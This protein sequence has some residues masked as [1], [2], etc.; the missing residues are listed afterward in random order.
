MARSGR[1][2]ST[3]TREA[4][5]MRA[6]HDVHARAVWGYA[7][8]LTRGD[9]ARAEDIVQETL[10]RAWRHPEVLDRSREAVRAWLLTTARRIAI[11]DWRRRSR[12]PE[13]LTDSPD[14]QAAEDLTDQTLQSWLVGDALGRLSPQHQAVIVECYYHGRT[15]AEAG[16]R[17]GIPEGTV[18]SRLHYALSSLRLVLQEMGVEDD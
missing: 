15:A 13:I 12:R 3:V 6:L 9:P 18:R 11:D 7:L 10:L 5:L 4:E 8:S 14:D 1:F 2:G 16:R 17:L